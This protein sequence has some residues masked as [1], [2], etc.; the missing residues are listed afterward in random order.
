[1]A[2]VSV[3]FALLMWVSVG[4]SFDSSLGVE[5]THARKREEHLRNNEHV[6]ANVVGG[7]APPTRRVA[8]APPV[9]VLGVNEQCIRRLHKSLSMWMSCVDSTV[10]AAAGSSKWQKNN[11]CGFRDF[12]SFEDPVVVG[13]FLTSVIEAHGDS[14]LRELL[15]L[16]VG[17]LRMDGTLE[18]KDASVALRAPK[19]FTRFVKNGTLLLGGGAAM[20]PSLHAPGCALANESSSASSK[21]ITSLAALPPLVSAVDGRSTVHFRHRRHT[22]AITTLTPAAYRIMFRFDFLPVS[23]SE[24]LDDTVPILSFAGDGGGPCRAHPNAPSVSSSH[25]FSGPSALRYLLIA[26]GSHTAKM[27]ASNVSAQDYAK[28]V[29]DPHSEFASN[30]LFRHVISDVEDYI[31]WRLLRQKVL[32]AVAT[33]API[34][35]SEPSLSAHAAD[36]ASG[37]QADAPVD[38]VVLFEETLECESMGEAKLQGFRDMAIHC[39]LMQS[40]LHRINEHIRVHFSFGEWKNAAV[41]DKSTIVKGAPS[42]ARPLQSW[43]ERLHRHSAIRHLLSDNQRKVLAQRVFLVPLLDCHSGKFQFTSTKPYCTRDGIHL[44]TK[45]IRKKLSVLLNVLLGVDKC[46]EN[47]A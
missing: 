2:F 6:A 12:A 23:F 20:M 22:T 35:L 28:R 31:I 26:T 27:F 17:G 33:G 34:S 43:T 10:P 32:R 36:E 38:F 8:P 47:Q 4:G 5:P 30:E 15:K 29:A 39:K 18:K 1:M 37:D 7:T 14:T 42:A 41:A 21:V 46:L 9:R 44:R 45:F 3:S 13:I 40:I 25:F 24:P 16:L 19:Y 11:A